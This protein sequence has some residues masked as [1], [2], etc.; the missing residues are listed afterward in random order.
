MNTPYLKTML[1]IMLLIMAVGGIDATEADKSSVST[2]PTPEKDS[3]AARL[4]DQITPT[5]DK[6]LATAEETEKLPDSAWWGKDKQDNANKLNE[7]LNEAVTILSTS[8]TDEIRQQIKVYEQQIRAAKNTIDQY[9]QAQ[10]SAPFQSTW[11]TTVADYEVK[12]KQLHERIDQWEKLIL[13]RK[14]DFAQELSKTGLFLTQA[15]LDSLLSSVVGDNLIQ[16]STVYENA[17]QIT[18]QLMTLTVNS[19]EDVEIS[20]RYYGLYTVLLK[21]LLH[22][23]QTFISQI[24]DKYLPHLEKIVLTVQILSA[25]SHRLLNSETDENRRRHLQANLDAQDLTLKA[26]L[27][28][29]QHLTGYR[30]KIAAVRDKTAIDLQIAENT[31]KTVKVSGELLNLLRTSQKSF[32]LLLNLQTPEL[33]IFENLQMKQEFAQLSEKLKSNK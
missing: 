13:Q 19:G 15:Q 33:L 24:D 26:A 5:L 23:Q 1:L 18:Q 8:N 10:V 7:L 22:L 32:N 20:K 14:A 3:L 30:S 2:A 29:K 21:T 17:K 6:L 31:Y 16:S 28:Y 12:I 25:D 27:L 9:R 11:K 4:W